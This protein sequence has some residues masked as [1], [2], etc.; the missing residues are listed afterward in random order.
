V[1]DSELRPAILD[2]LHAIPGWLEDEAALFTIHLIEAQRAAGLYGSMLEIG[3]YR[4][5]YLSLLRLLLADE[6]ERIIGVE[7]FPGGHAEFG[8]Q[9]IMR[10]VLVAAGSTSNV[11]VLEADS[12]SL[13][14]EELLGRLGSRAKFAHIDG[15]HTEDV[16]FRD[17]S[18]VSPIMMTGGIIAMDDAFSYAHPGVTEALFRFLDQERHVIAP[19][20]YCFNKLFLTTVSHYDAY[21]AEAH[22]FVESPTAP[23]SLERVKERIAFNR[24][25]DFAPKLFGYEILPIG[26]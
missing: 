20:A 14:S 18:I 10:N 12:R 4:G 6:R 11:T 22:R 24:S 8:I 13:S 23:K 16:V 7:L 19:F 9:E 25:L 1:T 21:F 17:L 5:K 3:V 26:W 15:G 2:R